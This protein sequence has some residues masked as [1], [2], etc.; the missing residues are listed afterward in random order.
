MT[1]ARLRR[2]L[3]PNGVKPAKLAILGSF[4]TE[5]LSELIQLF[6]FATGIDVE[7]GL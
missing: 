7:V 4:T 6:L 2:G 3:D 1:L 5:Q